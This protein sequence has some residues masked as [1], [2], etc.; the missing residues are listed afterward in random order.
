MCVYLLWTIYVAFVLLND[1]FVCCKSYHFDKCLEFSA[2][3]LSR[4]YIVKG[5]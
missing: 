2:S 4:Y 3:S 5:F 1:D